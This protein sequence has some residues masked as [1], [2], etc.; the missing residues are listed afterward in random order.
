ME[1]SKE[2][3]CPDTHQYQKYKWRCGPMN[4][5]TPVQVVT[6]PDEFNNIIP[7]EI[8]W[9]D[10]RRYPIQRIL[11]VCQPEDMILRYT[12]LIKGRQRQLFFNGSEWRVSAPNRA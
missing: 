6:R 8:L 4:G 11:H 5:Y 1:A 3:N 7:I 12:V 10:D 9:S 2:M